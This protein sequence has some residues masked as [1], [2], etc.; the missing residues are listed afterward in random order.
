MRPRPD[1]REG[2][3][4]K[5]AKENLAKK[6]S[7]LESKKEVL[8][9]QSSKLEEKCKALQNEVKNLLQK[10]A[11]L[12]NEGTLCQIL[13]EAHDTQTDVVPLT[14]RY[15]KDLFTWALTQST[16]ILFFPNFS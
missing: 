6:V 16:W 4:D 12:S 13:N 8:E 3:V 1:H 9:E 2:Y 5:Y 11:K 10:N 14:E 15:K 7:A